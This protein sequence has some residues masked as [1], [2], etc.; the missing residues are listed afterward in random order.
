MLTSLKGW[1]DLMEALPSSV[2]IRES[3]NVYTA[4]LA[5]HVIGMCVFAG[6]VLMMDLRLIGVGN[7]RTPFSQVQKR[8][9]PWQ[10]AGMLLS[11]V[12]GAV[13]I[14]GQPSRFYANIF[15]W[16]KMMMMVLAAVN[17]LAFHRST[18]HTVVTWDARP[19]TPFG[20]KLSGVLSVALWAGVVV[21]GRMIAYN[22]FAAGR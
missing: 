13:L 11:A 15:F 9:F 14:Y 12:T 5:L 19:V 1:L 4:L 6:L 22:W 17:A 16:V 21:A 18:Y 8:L 3:I 20:A 2:A 10:M 7:M